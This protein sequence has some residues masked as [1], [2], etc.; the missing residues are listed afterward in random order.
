VLFS[1]LWQPERL[2]AIDIS[3]GP[4]PALTDYIR[5]CG[6]TDSV[7][8][9]FGVNQADTE[10]VR[11]IIS[12]EFGGSL[13]DLVV[14]DGCHFFAETRATFEAAFPSVRPGGLYVIEDWAWAHWPGS[15][16]EDG[17]LWPEKQAPTLLVLELA[18]LCA[19]RPDLV[20]S[21]KVT[22]N[23]VIVH[24]GQGKAVGSDFTLSANYLTAGRVFSEEGF[25]TQ[26]RAVAPSESVREL[27]GRIDALRASNSWRV[28]APLRWIGRAMRR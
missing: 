26:S 17:G 15:W 28:T 11:S 1:E 25:F 3:E 4:I 16:Q 8:P 9:L 10:A 22:P 21:V 20:E 27:Q 6:L 23:L 18:M 19:S 13:L 7:R 2:V 24:R 14:D 5:R 12:R